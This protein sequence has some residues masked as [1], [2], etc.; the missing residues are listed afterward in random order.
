MLKARFDADLGRFDFDQVSAIGY[1]DHNAWGLTR[2]GIVQPLEDGTI[3]VFDLPDGGDPVTDAKFF[4]LHSGNGDENLALKLTTGNS[5]QWLLWQQAAWKTAPDSGDIHDAIQNIED[6][7]LANAN[8]KVSRSEINAV[9]VRTLQ[10][11]WP[12]DPDGPFDTVT[13]DMDHESFPARFDF[14]RINDFAVLDDHLWIATGHGI[15]LYKISTRQ[16]IG[17]DK[18]SEQSPGV[19][20]LFL[21]DGAVFASSHSNLFRNDSNSI[22]GWSRYEDRS[23]P[24]EEDPSLLDSANWKIVSDDNGTDQGISISHRLAEGDKRLVDVELADDGGGLRFDFDTVT[25]VAGSGQTV[26]LVSQ[27][28]LIERPDSDIGSLRRAS[29]RAGDLPKDADCEVFQFG[30][31]GAV[32]IY[33]DSGGKLWKQDDQSEHWTGVE[34]GE[35]AR[36]KE[37][38]SSIA[39]W[40]AF[41]QIKHMQSE[42]FSFTIGMP[43]DRNYLPTAFNAEKGLFDFDIMH[44]AASRVESNRAEELFVATDDGV[45]RRG[46]D[47]DGLWERRYCNLDI[48]GVAPNTIYDLAGNGSPVIMLQKASGNGSIC[49]TYQSEEDLWVKSD[50]A[51]ASAEPFA[52]FESLHQTGPGGWTVADIKSYNRLSPTRS[53]ATGLAVGLEHNDQPIWLIDTESGLLCAHDVV[54]NLDFH[55]DRLWLATAGGCLSYPVSGGEWQSD[56]GLQSAQ[57]LVAGFLPNYDIWNPSDPPNVGFVEKSAAGDALVC[58]LLDKHDSIRDAQYDTQT[59]F[60]ILPTNPDSTYSEN[61]SRLSPEEA[62]ATLRVLNSPLWWWT[63]RGPFHFDI[64]FHEDAADLPRNYTMLADG[65]FRFFDISRTKD[66]KKLHRA[67]ELSPQLLY[68]ATAGGV[69]AFDSHSGEPRKLFAQSETGYGSGT[70][71][72]KSVRRLF[73]NDRDNSLTAEDD[74]GSVFRIAFNVS[75]PSIL[76]IFKSRMMTS[77]FFSVLQAT[78]S[79]PLWALSTV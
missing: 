30:P 24:Q 46:I 49:R 2:R 74:S 35:A 54:Y 77:G 1:F 41:W 23:P 32:N 38:R 19:D 40:N 60:V 21:R 6:T 18:L 3:R 65:A 71:E 55:K 34:T 64:G 27:M 26:A 33:C 37:D 4:V 5:T 11:R 51:D 42:Q 78:P 20:T 79:N 12:W 52:V 17:C 28:G 63:K 44:D 57:H 16:F 29:S 69:I 45:V 48:D 66:R 68:V 8:W 31:E 70:R 14:E 67:T 15:L 62:S 25:S 36:I 10:R 7:L 75:M 50:D 39:A 73:Y 58:F 59:S 53:A 43:Q 47:A 13:I 22:K 72:I 56:M 61:T 9:P 76:G